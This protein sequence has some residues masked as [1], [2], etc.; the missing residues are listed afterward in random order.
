[1]GRA[2]WVNTAVSWIGFRRV[3]RGGPMKGGQG[4]W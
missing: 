1:M 2:G 4:R 3:G